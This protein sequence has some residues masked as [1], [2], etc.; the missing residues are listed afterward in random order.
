MGNSIL[1][2]LNF[3]N[4]ASLNYQEWIN[5]GMALKA[6]G[7]EWTVWDE[8]SKNDSRYKPGECERKWKSFSGS[9]TPLMGGTIIQMAKNNG[10]IP[11]SL[12][13]DGI[14][15]W[16]SVIEYDGDGVVYEMPKVESPV[17][18]LITY[19][20]TLYKDDELVSYCTNDV[21]QDKDGKWM[22]SKGISDRTAGQLI[23][24]LEKHPEDIGATIGDWKEECGAWIRFNPVDGKGIK[25]ENITRFEYALVES[26][27]MPISEQDATYRRLELPIAC[28]V[29]SGGKSIH[30]IVKVNAKDY[31]EYRKRVDFLYDFL[32]KN[33]LKV[34]KQNRNPSRLSRMPG[35][36]RNG[37]PQTL[38]ATNI[39]RR[40]WVEWMDFVEGISDELPSLTYLADALKNPIILPET[41]ISGVLRVGHKMIVSG[42]SKAGKSF[43]LIELALALASG[44]T[45]LG[46]GCKISRVLYINLEI[47]PASC[48]NR[49][50]TIMETKR[51]DFKHADNI[52]IWNL[53]GNALPMDKLVSKLIRR[54]KNQNYSAVIIDPIYKVIT[55]D[56]NN[57]SE[58]GK[59]C[60]YFDRIC[61]ETGCSAIYCHHHSKGAQ[62]Q[63]K[64]QDRGSGSG[65]FA[66][67]P[68][69][70]IDLIQLDTTPEFVLKNAANENSTAWR[71][72]GSLREFPNFKPVNCWFNYPI[73]VTDT[74]GL[75]STTFA[76][77]SRDANLAKSGKRKQTPASRKEEF[78]DAFAAVCLG[79]KSCQVSELAEFMGL[80]ERTVQSRIQEF[81]SEY[82]TRKKEVYKL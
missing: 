54:I 36:T 44:M 7:Y 15:D 45:W 52:T 68:D 9:S 35:V 72:E 65:V 69:A 24:S 64:A 26:D 77:G 61:S 16:D 38:L 53:R 78:D 14:L 66:R 30:A 20:K 34:D 8:W 58:M 75:L 55:G 12:D 57:A 76:E 1:N 41:L 37:N 6:E 29:S 27:D 3:I 5:I 17:Q 11:Y 32:D 43:L 59:F 22:P 60:N 18:Q 82:V 62:G 80:S 13:G 56:E 10:Y 2:A 81:S 19:L 63:K 46:F 51:I 42:S 21:W 40:D 4:V 23:K 73:H 39:G 25:N 28:L 74:I 48:I 50:K 70:I 31:E 49:F 67:D 47:D 71:V 79:K 33:S